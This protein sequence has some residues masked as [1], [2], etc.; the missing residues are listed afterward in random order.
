MF[1]EKPSGFKEKVNDVFV[2]PVMYQPTPKGVAELCKHYNTKYNIDMQILEIQH[3]NNREL[4]RFETLN[5]S[6]LLNISEGKSRGVILLQEQNHAVPVII[7]KQDNKLMIFIFDST[8]GGCTKAYYNVANLFPNA[9]VYLNSGTRQADSSSCITD[10]ICIV[11]DALR[12]KNLAQ[13]IQSKTVKENFSSSPTASK[14][15]INRITKPNNFSLFQMPEQLLKTAQR[16]LYLEHAD[17]N[18]VITP[19]KNR[20]LDYYRNK[21]TLQV[22]LTKD[23]DA[24]LPSSTI[25]TYLFNKSRKHKKILTKDNSINKNISTTNIITDSASNKK[26]PTI[27]KSTLF[28]QSNTGAPNFSTETIRKLKQSPLSGCFKPK[29]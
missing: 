11:K 10:A 15:K 16:S 19:K 7:T 22:S 8:S 17:K 20:T 27:P 3:S 13:L 25:N 14:L 24:N 21:Y 4:K 9:L 26:L 18:M 6:E 5:E 28:N 12:I 1:I 29:K 23:L 2:E